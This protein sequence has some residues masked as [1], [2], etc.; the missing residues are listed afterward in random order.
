MEG[1]Q[2]LQALRE[3]LVLHNLGAH[4]P[5]QRQIAG[6]AA[7]SSE[8]IVA[9]VGSD[10]W[11]GWRNGLGVRIELDDASFVGASTV[12]FS[13]VLAQFFSLY[14]SVNRFVQTSLVRDGRE[15]RTWRPTMGSPLVL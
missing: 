10:R 8:P 7:V 3:M 6:L 11:R 2:A 9:H 14:A 12:L 15:I 5:A 13:G 1:P 4:A